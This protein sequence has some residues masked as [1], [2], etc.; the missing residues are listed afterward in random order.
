MQRTCKKLYREIKLPPTSSDDSIAFPLAP[1]TSTSSDLEICF[2]S[3]ANAD[4]IEY[5]LPHES[6]WHETSSRFIARPDA[7]PML[8]YSKRTKKLDLFPL[9]ICFDYI[10]TLRPQRPSETSDCP[11]TRRHYK[12]RTPCS[13]AS[14]G[15]D[16]I[17]CRSSEQSSLP[18][19]GTACPH[20]GQCARE[21]GNSLHVSPSPYSAVHM[22]LKT[23]SV[24]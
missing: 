7:V 22:S 23:A 20:G 16:G 18:Q 13:P 2:C 3:S 1:R 12:Y 14:Y 10:P 11:S 8:Q 24:V 9:V 5:A 6:K 15:E 17:Y 4:N 21:V 19:S